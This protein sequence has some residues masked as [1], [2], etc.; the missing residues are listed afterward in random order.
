[1]T[2][3]SGRTLSSCDLRL[4]DDVPTMLPRGKGAE[5]GV[6]QR[7][8]GIARV[9]ARQDGADGQPVRQGGLHVLHG[10]HGDVDLVRQQRLLDFLGK[11]AFA[12]DIRQRPVGHL[13]ARRLDGCDRNGAFG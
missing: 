7:Y 4:S 5:V 8:E 11:E 10:V 9:L 12:A 2:R 6:L 13:V 1:M 3:R